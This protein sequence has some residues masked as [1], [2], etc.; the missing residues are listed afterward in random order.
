M[1]PK[2][3]ILSHEGPPSGIKRKKRKVREGL[4]YIPEKGEKDVSF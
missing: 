3:K 2:I 1:G 4:L